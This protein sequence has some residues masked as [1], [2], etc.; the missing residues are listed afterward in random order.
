MISESARKWVTRV[1]L[2]LSLLLFAG[3]IAYLMTR[4]GP[5]SIGADGEKIT[6]VTP[7]EAQTA[8]LLFCSTL[9]SFCIA[10]GARV[11][12]D[13][14]TAGR[15][16]L[17]VLQPVG[18]GVIVAAPLLALAGMVGPA[19]A[20]GAG[21]LAIFVLSKFLYFV[22]FGAKEAVEHIQEGIIEFKGQFAQR[23]EPQPF[24]LPPTSFLPEGPSVGTPPPAVESSPPA[25]SPP[26]T[27][28]LE[29][30]PTWSPPPAPPIGPPPAPGST[31]Q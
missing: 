30:P 24:F 26:P 29:P 17:G 16:L 23:S 1:F 27:P 8:A 28:A 10:M 15:A 12:A 2:A 4:T 7:A 5:T 11:L 9:W 19:I 22:I 6:T 21:G 14:S 25:W 20:A 31:W 3:T 18:F 13:S